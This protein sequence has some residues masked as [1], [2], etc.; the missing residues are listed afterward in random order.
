MYLYLIAQ[1]VYFGIFEIHGGYILW[2]IKNVQLG[3]NV[4]NIVDR[5]YSIYY[6]FLNKS[7]ILYTR[8]L[9]VN[10][11]YKHSIGF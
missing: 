6:I 5:F 7:S 9:H 2:R 11:F 10:Q 3:D 4:L 8:C 1:Y